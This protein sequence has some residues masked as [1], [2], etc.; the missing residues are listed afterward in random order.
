MPTWLLYGFAALTIVAAISGGYLW[1]DHTLVSKDKEISSLRIDLAAAKSDLVEALN[2]VKAQEKE[3]ANIRSDL[4]FSQEQADRIK[5]QDTAERQRQIEVERKIRD[6][7][8]R[9]SR[10]LDAINK[11]QDCVNRDPTDV[12]CAQLLQ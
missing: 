10:S 2:T 4:N 1:L 7:N 5:K 12:T 8:T 11:Y 9:D 6:I 3:I